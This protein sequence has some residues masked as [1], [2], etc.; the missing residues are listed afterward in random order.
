MAYQMTTVD[1]LLRVADPHDDL[2]DVEDAS[3][4]RA[5][6]EIAEKIRAE[7]D[8][9]VSDLVARLREY[10]CGY[11]NDRPFLVTDEAANRIEA[12]LAEANESRRAWASAHLVEIENVGRLKAEL[13]AAKAKIA[14]VWTIHALQDGGCATCVWCDFNY[15]CSTIH[16]LIFPAPQESHAGSLAGNPLR[17]GIVHSGGSRL[18]DPEC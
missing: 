18:S 6:Y 11:C 2:S 8:N 16:A 13:A 5:T 12:E 7:G 4:W 17:E 3:F 14:A 10:T 9:T 15:P 1:F